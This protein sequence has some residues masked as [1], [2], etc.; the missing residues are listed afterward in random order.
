MHGVPL[1]KVSRLTEKW[2]DHPASNRVRCHNEG[3]LWEVKKHVSNVNSG[4][5]LKEMQ[6]DLDVYE[7]MDY[8]AL[9]KVQVELNI[10]C[11]ARLTAVQFHIRHPNHHCVCQGFKCT[12][13]QFHNHKG[14][15]TFH[16]VL[17]V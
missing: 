14:K 7:N 4:V 8:Q 11:S 10:S 5:T 1:Y 17:Y 15:L 3:L 13:G 2:Q 12:R 6:K 16:K 9:G